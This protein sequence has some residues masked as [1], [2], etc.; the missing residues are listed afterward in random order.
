VRSK[1]RYNPSNVTLLEEYL[2]AQVREGHY[3]LFAN[4][5]ILKLCVVGLQRAIRHGH[6]NVFL[7]SGQPGTNSTRDSRHP[8]SSSKSSSSR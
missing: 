4:L 3:D 5:A 6:T 1:D 2:D 7:P 8:T